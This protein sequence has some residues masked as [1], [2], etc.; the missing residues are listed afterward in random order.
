MKF[1][2]L[3]VS[4]HHCAQTAQGDAAGSVSLLRQTPQVLTR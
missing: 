2:L 3:C 1:W 4:S